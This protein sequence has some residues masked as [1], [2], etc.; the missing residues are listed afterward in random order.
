M[1]L[2]FDGDGPKWES[3]CGSMEAG[4]FHRHKKSP[5]GPDF[6]VL[7][8]IQTGGKIRLIND[9]YSL[10]LRPVSLII[11]YCLLPLPETAEEMKILSCGTCLDSSFPILS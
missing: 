6:E 9:M 1:Y 5:S 10:E 7:N 8:L 3:K 11:K 4:H 2:P